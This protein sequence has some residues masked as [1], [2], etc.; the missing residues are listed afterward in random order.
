MDGGVA[1]DTRVC[2]HGGV[3]SVDPSH[4]KDDPKRDTACKDLSFGLAKSQNAIIGKLAHKHL[5]RNR[6]EEVAKASFAGGF[7]VSAGTFALSA[8][9]GVRENEVG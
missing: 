8:G 5:D 4:L 7:A 6:L 9:A 3:R 2:Y 1:P